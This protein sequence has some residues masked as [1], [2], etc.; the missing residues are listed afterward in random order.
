[1]ET[2]DEFVW[3]KSCGQFEVHAIKVTIKSDPVGSESIAMEYK[4][5]AESH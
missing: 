3:S 5:S 4:M 2:E 1:M